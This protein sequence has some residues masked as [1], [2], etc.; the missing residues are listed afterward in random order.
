MELK[1]RIRRARE[2]SGLTQAQLAERIGVDTKTVRN[3]EA[4]RAPR[5]SL[6]A[7]ETVLGVSLDDGPLT[8]DIALETA[9]DAQLLANVA[10]RLARRDQT[11]R[12]LESRVRDLAAERD[13]LAAE[14][15]GNVSTILAKVRPEADHH[16]GARPQRWAARRREDPGPSETR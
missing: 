16:D 3:W 14:S 8:S 11:I 10:D 15:P 12:D 6:G 13:A 7:I 2:A 1:D 9:T 4:G 5:R